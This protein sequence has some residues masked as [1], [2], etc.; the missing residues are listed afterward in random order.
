MSLD[1][2]LEATEIM[3]TIP[4][5]DEVV[6]STF[7]FLDLAHYGFGGWR[8][9][10]HHFRRW[11]KRWNPG[12]RVN[13]LDV[14]AGSGTL[15]L[16]LVR[17][18]RREGFDLKVTGLELVPEIAALARERTR[19]YPE[20]TVV[21]SDFFT[22]E[23]KEPFD[24]VTGSLF[25]HHVP[26]AK[27]LE[28]L[29]RMDRWARRGLVLSDLER[30]RTALWGVIAATTLFG[31]SITRHD[32]PLSVRRAFTPQELADLAAKTGLPYLKVLNHPFFR[33]TL[34]GEK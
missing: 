10:G 1:E 4:L 33:L 20:V 22:W 16:S 34:A 5:S 11:S 23:P 12:E 19:D 28:A 32:G 14:G 6:R 31:N 26:G 18:A 24:Y 21:E 8:S 29:L 2:R 7:R 17:W 25:L 3:D 15:A 13:C 30:C 9:I 27:L